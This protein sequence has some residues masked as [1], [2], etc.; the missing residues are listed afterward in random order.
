MAK[1]NQKISVNISRKVEH[2][3]KER[4]TFGIFNN[5]LS[6]ESTSCIEVADDRSVIHDQNTPCC[7]ASFLQLAFLFQHDNHV[8]EVSSDQICQLVEPPLPDQL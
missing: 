6:V 1:V 4:K 7:A 3:N 2:L 5:E 8:V